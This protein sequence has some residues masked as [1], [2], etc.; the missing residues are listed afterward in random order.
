MT[1]VPDTVQ[2]IT[3]STGTVLRDNTSQAASVGLTIASCSTLPVLRDIDTIEVR[4]VS[5]CTPHLIVHSLLV[6]QAV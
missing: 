3:W 2:G 6:A 4:N 1:W 5:S